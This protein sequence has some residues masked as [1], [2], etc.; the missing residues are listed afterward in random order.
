MGN[1]HC[2]VF[3]QDIESLD[4]KKLGPDFENAPI[5]PERV[6]T[7]FVKVIDSN[8]LKMRV[9]ERGCGE[10]MACG[11]GA[12]AVAVAGGLEGRLDGA[13]VAELPGGELRLLWNRRDDHVYMLGPATIVFEGTWLGP[14]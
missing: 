14:V 2:V 7:E 10:T 4:V 5:F 13:V 12:C 6:N 11:T 1:P 3:C 8:T 9:W